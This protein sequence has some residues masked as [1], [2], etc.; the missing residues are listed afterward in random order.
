MIN[1]K[2]NS[3]IIIEDTRKSRFEEYQSDN[4]NIYYKR[5]DKP[6]F[7]EKLTSIPN[8]LFISEIKNINGAKNVTKLVTCY[9]DPNR[10]QFVLERLTLDCLLFRS[11]KIVTKTYPKWISS[12]VYFYENTKNQKALISPFGPEIIFENHAKYFGEYHTR[13]EFN[14][15]ELYAIDSEN[16]ETSNFL[17]ML[18]YFDQAE[19]LHAILKLPMNDYDDFK[20]SRHVYSEMNNREYNLWDRDEEQSFRGFWYYFNQS[21]LA[22]EIAKAMYDNNVNNSKKREKIRAKIKSTFDKKK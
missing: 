17:E 14:N 22:E 9:K 21:T 7:I 11:K 15:V 12:G 3:E 20:V 2:T 16:K 13:V 6:N 10:N 4:V 19:V 18:L 8:P 1:L 5:E